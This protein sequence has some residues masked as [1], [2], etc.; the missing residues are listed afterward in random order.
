MDISKEQHKIEE[1]QGHK[2]QGYKEQEE[3]QTKPKVCAT[4]DDL[5]LHIKEWIKLDN[6]IIKLKSQV[7]EKNNKKKRIDRNISKRNEK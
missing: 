1:E 3:K 2:E 6:D 4:K 5:I 7:K